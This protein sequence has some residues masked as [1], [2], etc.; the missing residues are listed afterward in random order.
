VVAQRD[1]VG[2]CGEQPIGELGGDAGAVGDVLAVDDA[3]VRAEL[4]AQAG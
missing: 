4:F 3:D 2:T 1:H